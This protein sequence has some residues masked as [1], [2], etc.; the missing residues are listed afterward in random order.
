M[1][2]LNNKSV[3]NKQRTK[4][5]PAASIQR[6]SSRSTSKPINS[7]PTSGKIL[8][9]PKSAKPNPTRKLSPEQMKEIAASF[10]INDKALLKTVANIPFSM[11]NG[12]L[13]DANDTQKFTLMDG[14]SNYSTAIIGNS[15]SYHR[16]PATMGLFFSPSFAN[17]DALTLA[18]RALYAKVRSKNSGAYNYEAQDL[19]YYNIMMAS[20]A[21]AYA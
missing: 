12:L 16:V 19:M 3:N 6:N 5:G 21:S 7:K 14:T 17:A 9:S 4:G 2:S 15:K 20:L 13:Y 11:I 18:A 10:F 8:P 1:P